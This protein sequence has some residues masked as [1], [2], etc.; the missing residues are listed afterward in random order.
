MQTPASHPSDSWYVL[1]FGGTSVARRRYWDTI[2]K[3]AQQHVAHPGQRVLIVVSALSGVTNQLL[4]IA[5]N[6][7]STPELIAS[8]VQKHRD[9]CVDLDLDPDQTLGARLAVLNALVS[10]AE[11]ASAPYAW[12]AEILSQ[13]ELLSSALGVAYLQARHLPIGWVDARDWLEQEPQ[14]FD[15]SDPHGWAQRLSITCSCQA[16]P[17]WRERFAA[18]PQRILLTQGF[19]ARHADGRTALLGRGGSDTSAAYFGALL[20]AHRVEIW[21]DVPGMFSANPKEVPKAHLLTRLDYDEAQEIAATGANVLHPRAIKPCQKANIPLF[22]RDTARPE[23]TGTLI[24]GK[25]T[26]TV[27]VKAISRRNGIVLVSMESVKM[28]HQVGYLADLFAIFRALGLSVDMISAAQTNVTVSL[29]PADNQLHSAVLTHLTERLSILCQPTILR[30]CTSITFVGRGMRSLLNKLSPVWALFGQEQVHLL[31]QSSNSLNLTFV[32]DEAR[33][34]GLVA[35]LHA[36]LIRSQAMPTYEDQVFGPRWQQIFA[37]PSAAKEGEPWWLQQRAALLAMMETQ[38]Q[39]CYVYHRP[40]LRRQARWLQ[41]VAAIDHLFYAV[42]ANSHAAV[43]TTFAEEGF[44]FECVS[45]NE[46]DHVFRVLPQLDAQRIV[47]TPSFAA[48][49]EYSA[50]LTLGVNVTLDSVEILTQW[51]R[52]FQGR[53]VWLRVDLGHGD[54]H[55][56]KVVTGGKDAKFGLSIHQLDAF[57]AAAGGADVTIVGLHA[58]LG[59]GIVSVQH[60]RHVLEQLQLCAA[61]IPTIRTIDIG[62]GLPVPYHPEDAPFDLETWSSSLAQTKAAFPQYRLAL[63]PGR[64][65]TAQAGVL[66]SCVTQIV[67]KDGVSRVGVNAGMHT[68]LR[69]ALYGA[70][71]TIVNLS[72]VATDDME[73]FDVVGPICESSDI[74]GK[75]RRLPRATAPGDIVLIADAGAYGFVMSNTYNQRLL[76]REAILDS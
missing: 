52:V 23:L 9:F 58:H 5:Q 63:E 55:N 3:I 66:L 33:A 34:E 22:I 42:K 56:E 76:P 12:Q 7:P 4:A 50:A 40:T 43:L 29:D 67:R 57:V 30:P 2:G 15:Q 61:D 70:W 20:G 10:S 54:G 46:I 69:P 25:A 49:S 36:E 71:H 24:D 1:K 68:L 26:A 39:P 59:S 8:I 19:I 74:L 37:R 13:G 11:A 32:I 44:G 62:G 35:K 41:A 17:G 21:T 60:W 6:D 73:L 31:S 75:R 64:F 48:I 45:I 53:S 16:Q 18:Q 51:P 28:W 14:S 65:L 27:G 72:H 47:F 38:Q